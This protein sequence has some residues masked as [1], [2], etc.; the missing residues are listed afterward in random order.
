MNTKQKLKKIEEVLDVARPML[1]SH[2]GGIS[3]VDLNDQGVLSVALQ[4]HCV[5]C[6]LS[7]HTMRLGIERLLRDN[8]PDIVSSVKEV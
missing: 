3:V 5:G 7:T 4:G 2:G 8:I 1:G 6:P